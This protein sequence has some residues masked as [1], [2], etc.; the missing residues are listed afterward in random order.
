M[1]NKTILMVGETG[2]GKTTVINTMV[3]LFLGVK[4]EDKVWFEITEEEKE[5]NESE[6]KTSEVTVYEIIS[7]EKRSSLTIID[8]PGYGHTEGI[9]K[10]MDIAQLLHE[11]FL[12]ETGVKDLDAV[13]FVLK[14][15]QNRISEVQHYIF[16]SV[17]SLF[18]KDIE[19]I[20][21]LFITH[22]DGLFP[23]NALEAVRA[24]EIPCCYDE[25]NEPVHFLFNNC[26]SERHK[27]TEKQKKGNEKVFKSAWE[28][29]EDSLKKFLEFLESREKI[30]LNLTVGVLEKRE[31]LQACVQSL[32]ERIEFTELKQK[33]LAQVQ[34]ALNQNK[35]EIEKNGNFSF[36][37]RLTYRELVDSGYVFDRTV[38]RCD[39]C[40]ENCH[41]Y[42]CWFASSAKDCKV[43]KDGYCTVCGCPYNKHKREGKKY[44]TKQKQEKV[45]FKDLKEKYINRQVQ[46]RYDEGAFNTVDKELGETLERK[47]EMMKLESRLKTLLAEAEEQKRSLVKEAYETI[48]NLSRIALKPNSAFT[49]V[50]LDFLI[51]RVEEAGEAGW[52]QKLKDIKENATAKKSTRSALKFL[53]M[54]KEYAL[55]KISWATT[56][57]Q[58]DHKSGDKGHAHPKQHS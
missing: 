31:Q 12:H 26:Q 4:F 36:S 16:E 25:D 57:S 34:E 37:V 33:E 58:G 18:S 41:Q 13:C 3:N 40:K 17:F 21:V 10:D 30:G 28:T 20:I 9:E 11:L 51:P 46:V 27:Q 53:Q 8:T 22:S 48:L 56:W 6:S 45:T 35:K 5:R 50:Y 42:F 47:Q 55:S 52:A 7:D 44:E 1:P 19:D 43:M 24:A 49:V 32:K 2:T 14:A 23:T 54:M 39:D 38:T 15:S 29:G